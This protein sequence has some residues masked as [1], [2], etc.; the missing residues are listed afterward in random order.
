LNRKQ[1]NINSALSVI[2]SIISRGSIAALSLLLAAVASLETLGFYATVT[3]VLGLYQAVFEGLIR[4][5]SGRFFL[6][7]STSRELKKIGLAGSFIFSFLVGLVIVESGLRHEVSPVL[8]ASAIP[9]CV[10]PV[11]I[12]LSSF[13]QRAAQTKNAWSKIVRARLLSTLPIFV[14]CMVGT[15]LTANLFFPALFIPLTELVMLIL[16]R[17][18]RAEHMEPK[19]QERETLRGKREIGGM[20]LFQASSWLKSQADR[21]VMAISASAQIMG[22]YFIAASIA[23]VPTEMLTYGLLSQQRALLANE[24][25]AEHRKLITDSRLRLHFWAAL[26]TYSVSILGSVLLYSYSQK[27]VIVATVIPILA[28]PTFL[29]SASAVIWASS[30]NDEGSMGKNRSQIW[31]T[32]IVGLMALIASRDII[33]GCL[34]LSIREIFNGLWITYKWRY[35]YSRSRIILPLAST[36]AALG[37]AL[38]LLQGS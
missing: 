38:A 18:N 24:P 30:I 36:I 14:F 20:I 4:N 13:Q 7:S 35:L 21:V 12:S 32:L 8:I 25:R 33:L 28:S 23:R 9:I 37:L 27:F 10:T 11:L 22:I 17:A 15:Y 34:L 3:L 16:L 19:A 5:I 1:N 29:S 6:F 26:L 2:D 31:N